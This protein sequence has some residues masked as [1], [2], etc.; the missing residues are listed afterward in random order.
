M[1]LASILVVGFLTLFPTL[2]LAQSVDELQKAISS[3]A[4]R[5]A[6]A[7]LYKRLGDTL[8]EQDNLEQ[9]A[10]AFSKALAA[11]RESFS[12]NERV[13]MAV[14]LSWAD[15]LQE[16]KE[17]L[18]RLLAQDPKNVPART[19]LARVLSWSCELGTA[20]TQAHIVLQRAHNDKTALLV[21]ANLLQ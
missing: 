4:D 13:Q 9:A 6:Q 20:I 2:T 18:N 3:T 7:K 19:Q 21:N 1:T 15:R 10:D 5:A 8:V 17:E 14:Y 16:S 12:A 11:G